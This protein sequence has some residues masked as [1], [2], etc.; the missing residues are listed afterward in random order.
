MADSEHPEIR[1]I[2]TNTYA[3]TIHATN[4]IDYRT[5]GA[6]TATIYL[7]NTDGSVTLADVEPEDT[8]TLEI[9]DG[10]S[11][12]EMLDGYIT[13]R[14]RIRSGNGRI[15]IELSLADYGGYLAAKLLGEKNYTKSTTAATIFADAAAFVSGL[16][17]NIDANT[18]AIKREFDGTYVK[19]MWNAAAE[20]GGAEWFCDETKTL[21]AFSSRMLQTGGVNYKIIDTAPGA[22]NEIRAYNLDE[23]SWEE[24]ATLRYRS[25]TATGGIAHTFPHIANLHGL[26]TGIVWLDYIGKNFSQYFR[27]VPFNDYIQPS[28]VDPIRIDANGLT[29]DTGASIPTLRLFPASTS[30]TLAAQIRAM[31][32]SQYNLTNKDF[33]IPLD[34]FTEL[35]F[36]MRNELATETVTDIKLTI[37]DDD[38]NYWE[39][40][41]KHNG[42]TYLDGSTISAYNDLTTSGGTWAYLRYYL[43]TSTSDSLNWSLSPASWYKTGT[44]TEIN[45][46]RIDFTPNTGYTGSV[47]FAQFYLY[48]KKRATVTGAGSPATKKILVKR[49]IKDST[50]LTNLATKEQARCNVNANTSRVSALGNVD[51]RKPGYKIDLDLS[52]TL[53]AGASGTDLRM[54]KIHHR[55]NPL[56]IMTIDFDNSA[57]QRA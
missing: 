45:H 33:A 15:L 23:Y 38:T 28:Q 21:Q 52:T 46:F 4:T 49:S 24:D 32:I 2:A 16:S 20:L 7:D 41:I 44:P 50:T 29:V 6:Q 40:K 56:W 36:F 5:N 47:G 17:T 10:S 31:D 55:L 37:F 51:F 27:F 30:Q 18:T 57:F 54:N 8:A 9:Y 42:G 11:L 34:A 1:L 39:Y 26:T 43:P 22:A 12:T 53:G 13:R 48:G 14:R 25:V 3:A 19:D 35:R